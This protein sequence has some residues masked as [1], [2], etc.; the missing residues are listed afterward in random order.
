VSPPVAFRRL[1]LGSTRAAQR[2]DETDARR[3]GMSLDDDNGHVRLE[4]VFLGPGEAVIGRVSSTSYSASMRDDEYFTFVIQRAGRYDLR[5]AGHDFGMS[6]R[7]LLAFR[8][9]ERTSRVRAG[10]TGTR[11]AV[12][13]QVPA[14]RMQALAQ[15]LEVSVDAMF[16]HDGNSLCG[17]GGLLLSRVLPQLADDLFLR[18]PGELPERLTTEIGLMIEEVLSES[19]GL[20]IE[21]Q[22]SRRIFPAFHRVRQAEELMHAH[23]DEPISMRDVAQL[24]GV[25][26][27]SL[28]L[29][30]AEVHGLTPRDVLGRIRLEKARARLLASDGDAAV[31]TVAMDSGLFHLGRFSQAYARAFG[32]KPSATLMRRPARRT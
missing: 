18:P 29:A 14:A 21:Q 27:R 13:L 2:D 3:L 6:P 4:Q 19:I 12:T 20:T 31:T 10:R 9:N 5:I 15:I 25:S 24:L 1:I 17:K 22:S 16:P 23:S 11:A 28:Q 8:P 30:F 7:D 26:L 32:E